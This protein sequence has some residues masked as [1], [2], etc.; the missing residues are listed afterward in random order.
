M[1]II[2][3]NTRETVFLDSGYSNGQYSVDNLQSGNYEVV[4]INEE[5]NCPYSEKLYLAG[6]E[7]CNDDIDNDLDG[8]IDNGITPTIST[9]SNPYKSE[10]EK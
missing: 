8:N 7:E 6:P 9:T 5:T 1:Q 10:T 3:D 4:V 2:D